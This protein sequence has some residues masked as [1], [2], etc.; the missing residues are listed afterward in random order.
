MSDRTLLGGLQSV[1][2]ALRYD[3]TRVIEVW[4][5]RR[6]RDGRMQ[7]LRELLANADAPVHE[8]EARALDRMLPDFP[9]QGV[10]MA[11]KG[12]SPRGDNDLERHL[13]GL[14]GE[15]FVLVLDQVQDPH[16]LGACLRSADAA[17]VDAV[18]V[19]RDRSAGLTA[20]VHRVSA[21]A[22][23][24]VPFFQV[25]NLAR[26]LRGL[27]DRGI[28]LLGAADEAAVPVYS[29]DM[30]GP[31]GL[32][33]GAE[34][35]GLRRLTREHCDQL[36]AIPMAGHVESLNVSVATGV[37]LFEARRQHSALNPSAG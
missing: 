2:S 21:G 11:Y 14:S 23:E 22:A 20:V 30:T 32:V 24:S 29:V 15:P 31:M 3:P 5:D 7:R 27:R 10:V 17:G 13:D 19:P 35:K 26:C 33:V 8:S 18:I 28:W 37:L 9:H 16:N 36:I 6:R 4:L 1:Q 12:V 25:T 34:G